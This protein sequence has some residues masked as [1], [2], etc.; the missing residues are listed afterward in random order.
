[1]AKYK[2]MEAPEN[3]GNSCKMCVLNGQNPPCNKSIYQHLF[4][5]WDDTK[6]Y[7]FIKVSEERKVIV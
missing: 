6:A 2:R 1:M 4:E 5:C 7:Y 3:C